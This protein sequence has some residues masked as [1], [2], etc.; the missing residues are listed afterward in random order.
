MKKGLA[1]LISA[2]A[3]GGIIS[4]G[5]TS[6]GSVGTNTPIPEGQTI[7]DA[8]IRINTHG[9]LVKVEIKEPKE[10]YKAGDKIALTLTFKDGYGLHLATINGKDIENVEN[11][12]L[13]EGAN[14]ID[15]FV[16]SLTVTEGS[17]NLRDFVFEATDG[18]RSYAITSYTPTGIYPNIVEIPS[19][20]LGKPV[21][22]IKFVTKEVINPDN[23]KDT[24]V[25]SR[26]LF[27]GL[28]GVKI[29]ASVKTID[30]RIF[31]SN[32][33]LQSITVDEKNTAYSSDGKVLLSKDKKTLVAFAQGISGEYK[34]PDTVTTIGNDAFYGTMKL[35]SVDFNNVTT[36]GNDAFNSV[37][38]IKEF[39]LTDKITTLGASAFSTCVETEKITLSNN[40]ETIPSNCFYKNSALKEITIP[41]SVKNI[42]DYAF[43]DCT[44][45]QKFTMNEGLE[46]IGRCAVSHNLIETFTFPKTLRKIGEAAFAGN[47]RAKTVTLNEGL[48]EIGKSAFHRNLRITSILIPSTVT[49]IGE[50]AFFAGLSLTEF[51]VSGEN[52]KYSSKEGVLF[53]KAGTTLLAYPSAKVIENKTYVIPEGT[54]TL[55]Y[56]CFSAVSN[57]PEG[58]SAKPYS[59]TKIVIPTSVTSMNESFYLALLETVEYKGTEAQFKAINFNGIV[60]NANASGTIKIVYSGDKQ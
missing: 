29:P 45:L 15:I 34:V 24:I 23:S 27:G 36:I 56:R 48:V 4:T 11:I 12:T 51:N 58:E 60:W 32:S 25:V 57:N 16:K 31:R 35:T 14:T 8:T 50:E 42:Q 38:G 21:T 22:E 26:Y 41:S 44:S 19:S 3:F 39:V 10:S 2:V 6:C 5:L 18:G 33:T 59:I 52:T 7:Q 55:A 54:T 43:Y 28:K 46:E 53:D 1:L 9:D 17:T 49:T 30:T 40:L 13:E 20:Y 37:K 47:D